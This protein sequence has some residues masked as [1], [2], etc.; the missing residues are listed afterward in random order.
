ML[1]NTNHT[2][3]V[4]NLSTGA[5]RTWSEVDT[6]VRVYINQI[7]EELVQGYDGAGSFTAYRMFTD[8]SH[9]TISIGD[10]V[11]DEDDNVYEVRSKS[12]SNDLTGVHHQYILIIKY[13]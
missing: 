7:S 8:G 11:T 9:E 12:I 4:S 10:R 13:E 1:F 3:S 2:I 5:K 6:D